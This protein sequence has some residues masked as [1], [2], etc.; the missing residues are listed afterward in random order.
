MG[1]L[2]SSKNETK[3]DF[4]AYCLLGQEKRILISDCKNIKDLEESLPSGTEQYKILVI[5]EHDAKLAEDIEVAGDFHTRYKQRIR[6]YI[7]EDGDMKGEYVMRDSFTPMF[8][9]KLDGRFIRHK[10]WKWIGGD[11]AVVVVSDKTDAF[12]FVSQMAKIPENVRAV[13]EKNSFVGQI[14][15]RSDKCKNPMN[16][17]QK[18]VYILEIAARNRCKILSIQEDSCGMMMCR[19]PRHFYPDLMS[20]AKN[21]GFYLARLMA[22][23]RERKK[24]RDKR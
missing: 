16:D 19:F 3:F 2:F 11:A 14:V 6:N 20:E 23:G 24:R 22:D 21:N 12:L 4:V 17:L 7:A 1:G 5:E 18:M 13:C 10:G 8:E 15:F 9:S